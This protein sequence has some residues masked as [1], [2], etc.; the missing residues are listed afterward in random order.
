[1]NRITP[2]A[3]A[4]SALYRSSASSWDKSLRERIHWSSKTSVAVSKRT[5]C[6]RRFSRSFAGSQ[7]NRLIFPVFF[8]LPDVR[9]DVNTNAKIP[10]K[11][12]GLPRA[13]GRP[14]GLLEG[15]LVQ[16]QLRA[17]GGGFAGV[18]D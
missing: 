6:L 9:T 3:I 1:M 11:D 7:T 12:L 18:P 4:P 16:C 2:G 5:P 14:K 13:S 15:F 10:T 17:E 8:S